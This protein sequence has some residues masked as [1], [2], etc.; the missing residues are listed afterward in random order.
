MKKVF[1]FAAFFT[2]LSSMRVSFGFFVNNSKELS[3][4]FKREKKN[5]R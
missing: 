2:T 5:Y 3:F 4:L 1:F